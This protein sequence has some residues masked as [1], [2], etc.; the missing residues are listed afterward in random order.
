MPQFA[1][2]VATVAECPAL[3]TDMPSSKPAAKGGGTSALTVIVMFVNGVYGE[4]SS[5]P[6]TG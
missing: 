2:I 1:V 4:L 6:K 5:T 3:I